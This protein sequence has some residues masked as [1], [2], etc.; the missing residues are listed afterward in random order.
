[1]EPSSRV[2]FHID[3]NSA[4]LSWESVYHL[5]LDPGAPDLRRIPSAVGGDPAQRHGVVLARSVPAKQAGVVTGEPL[6]SALR[7]CPDLVV[8]PSRF[9]VYKQYSSAMMRILEEYT[10]DIE[11]FSI[12]EA[13]LDM[14][15]TL[16]LF[17]D[18][19]ETAHRIRRRIRD[20]LGFTVNAGISSC[21]LLAKMASD[22]E[23]PDR[24]HT[25]WPHEIRQKMW[26]LP[27]RDLLFV[28]SSAEKKMRAIGLH[29]IGDLARC[30]LSVLKAHLGEKYAL[31]IH[32]WANGIDDSPVASGESP[33]KSFGSSVTL[34]RDISDRSDARQVLLSLSETVGTR[35]RRDGAAGSCV[36]VELKDW[37]FRTRS[38]QKILDAPTDSTARLYEAACGLL[39]ACW[40]LTPL[41][42][43]GLRVTRICE[44]GC[45]QMSLFDNGR[46]R[47]LQ[48]AERAVDCIRQK[49]GVDSIRRASFLCP[50]TLTDHAAGK[51][52]HLT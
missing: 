40:D 33:G 43:I 36:C 12:D 22:F 49:Y 42:L 24:V 44:T 19:L 32:A 18:V 15:G 41:R 17:G 39:D 37:K 5:S 2:I 7:K 35:L 28:G 21:R 13:F 48:E 4:F 11:K 10:P 8:V 3:V 14:T 9:A 26:P 34:P 38:H 29:T 16:H 25:L 20:E 1:M 52:K 30:D 23:K 46:T 27:V 47:K 50:D 31:Q 51:Q 45:G 6:A